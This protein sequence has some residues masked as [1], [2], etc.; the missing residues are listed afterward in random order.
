[1]SSRQSL[2]FQIEMVD[3]TLGIRMPSDEINAMLNY[4]Y[5][6]LESEVRRTLNSIGFDSSIGFLHELKGW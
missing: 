5:A 1:M 2:P 4:G 6:I 3:G